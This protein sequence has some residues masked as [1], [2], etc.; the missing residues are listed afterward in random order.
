V[1]LIDHHTSFKDLQPTLDVLQLKNF[2][3][4]FD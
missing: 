1:V 2:V 3:Y 4:L